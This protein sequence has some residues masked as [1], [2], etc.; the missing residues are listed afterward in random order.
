[1]AFIVIKGGSSYEVT[2]VVCDYALC[3]F[4][5][6]YPEA[7]LLTACSLAHHRSCH[8]A[9]IAGIQLAFGTS[10]RGAEW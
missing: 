4:R 1:M 3:Y 7:C 9:L 5:P 6:S 2:E 10:D 8:E